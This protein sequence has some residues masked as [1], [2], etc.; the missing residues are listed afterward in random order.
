[1]SDT[2]QLAQQDD[3][4]QAVA[5]RDG[6]AVRPVK[7]TPAVDVYENKQ[8]IT[9]WADLPGVSKDKLEI[10]VHDGRLSIEA[11]AVVATPAALRVQH[12]EMR[13][14]RFART[15]TL[16]PD[17]DTSK[18]EAE[19]RDGVLKLTIPRREEA[20]PRRIEVKTS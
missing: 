10:N 14:P 13:E 4:Q 1:M 5:R 2:N 7:V 16:S 8:G 17:L 9:L 6:E 12:V 3:Q 15:F 20:Q 18:V 11:E 19:L